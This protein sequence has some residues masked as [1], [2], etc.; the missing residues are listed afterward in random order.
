MKKLTAHTL[1]LSLAFCITLLFTA[2]GIYYLISSSNQEKLDK[3]S[4]EEQ[5]QIAQTEQIPSPTIVPSPEPSPIPTPETSATPQPKSTQTEK[6][7]NFLE[8]MER[9]CYEPCEFSYQCPSN[10]ECLEVNEVKICVS[11]QCELDTT[12]TCKATP[13]PEPKLDE[14]GIG[15]IEDQVKGLETSSDELDDF[16][17][18]TSSEIYTVQPTSTPTPTATPKKYEVVDLPQAGSME[19]TLVALAIGLSLSAIGFARAKK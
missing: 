9:S 18:I 11:S 7:G 12:C 10:L 2:T 13:T 19:L 8:E 16:N 14:A 17:E 5:K 15:G 3:I 6:L 1:Y 4:I